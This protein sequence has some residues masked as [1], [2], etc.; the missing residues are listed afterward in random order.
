MDAVTADRPDAAD[1]RARIRERAECV[2]EREQAQ[3]LDRLRAR[4]DLSE[5]EAAVIRD[6]AE[7]LTDGLLAVPKQHL[8]AVNSGDA[9]SE[10][11]TIALE[12]FGED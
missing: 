1:A 6:L 7:R 11:A 2:R 5:R 3:A 12:L 9:E 8:D 4:R 10:A